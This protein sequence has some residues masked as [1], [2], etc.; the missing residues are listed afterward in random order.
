MVHQGL[1]LACVGCILLGEDNPVLQHLKLRQLQLSVLMATAD[2]NDLTSE[3]ED[4]I[5]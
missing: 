1:V 2:A 3:E 4:G 5:Q